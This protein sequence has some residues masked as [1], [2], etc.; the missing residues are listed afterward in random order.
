[1]APAER[2]A[3]LFEGQGSCEEG[4]SLGPLTTLTTSADSSVVGDLVRLKRFPANVLDQRCGYLPL[5]GRFAHT[6]ESVAGHRRDR[7]PKRSGS[8]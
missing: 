3:G 1:M 7:C 5:G 8:G 4:N 6:Q 2:G